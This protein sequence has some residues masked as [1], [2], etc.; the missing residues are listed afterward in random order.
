[1][2]IDA[3]SLL[4][5]S[6]NKY[7]RHGRYAEYRL[8]HVITICVDLMQAT[9]ISYIYP[10]NATFQ[11]NRQAILCFYSNHDALD[12]VFNFIAMILMIKASI[13]LGQKWCK[14]C[15]LYHDHATIKY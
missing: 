14:T 7:Q 8:S 12:S 9:F 11:L 1:M 15:F 10:T 3:C 13:L 5:I 6:F 4:L 2:D